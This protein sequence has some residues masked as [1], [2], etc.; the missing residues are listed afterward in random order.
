MALAFTAASSKAD[1]AAISDLFATHG[2]DGFAAAWLRHRGLDL[3]H[4]P[5][6][7]RHSAT[8]SR[9][10]THRPEG[11][12]NMTRNPERPA[13]APQTRRRI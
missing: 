11:E 2:P 9:T 6:R 13:P 4:R 10:P 7:T 12:Q 3:G 1:Q 5:A 8:R